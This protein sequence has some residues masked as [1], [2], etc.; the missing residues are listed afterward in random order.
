MSIRSEMQPH[1]KL[2]PG[3][4]FSRVIVCGSPER[5]EWFSQRLNDSI[6]LAKNREYHSFYGTYQGT[7]ILIL[8][9][10][11][12]AAGAA[13]CFR[14]LIHLG[15]KKIIRLGTAGGIL[16]NLSRG[17]IVLA[18][19]AVREDGASLQMVPKSFPAVADPFLTEQ[20]RL[21]LLERKR[22]ISPG[23]ILTSDLFYSELLE[24]KY[25]LWQKAK[26]QAVE[27][28]A[29]TLFVIGSLHEIKTAAAFVLDGNVL[30]PSEYNPDFEFLEPAFEDLLEASL[31]TLTKDPA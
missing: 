3:R 20:L 12:G 30:R 10:G 23:T 7:P 16:E 17:D 1:L 15:A 27:M 4:D 29:S 31:Q 22:K 9:H 24:P 25:L 28:E 11:V 5:A 6:S 14:E 19:S 21:R 8:S 13:I 26:V 2:D 18:H